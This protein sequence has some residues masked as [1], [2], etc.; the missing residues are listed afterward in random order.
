MARFASFVVL[1]ISL[2][3][4]VA[5]VPAH[6]PLAGMPIAKRDALI[7]T[8]R[9]VKPE[10]PPPPLAFNG[11]K[12]VN[13]A[14]HPWKPLRRGDQR[15]PCP[16]LNTLASHGVSHLKYTYGPD[17]NVFHS[18]FLVMVL[19]HRL[20]SSMLSKKVRKIVLRFIICLTST[21]YYRIQCGDY[22]RKKIHLCRHPC[23]WKP[24]H[25]S[26]QHW[27]KVPID[28]S[29]SRCTSNHWWLG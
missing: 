12:L 7:E 26:A 15:G 18:I 3:S 24:C 17:L 22:P 2:A 6:I 5:A 14:A 29:R 28:R 16:G 27:P 11:T 1:A 10:A 8:L 9:A 13:D 4:S 20:N 19:L 25:Q 21:P 23:R